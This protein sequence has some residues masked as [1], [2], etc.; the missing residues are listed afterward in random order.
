MLAGEL[1]ARELVERYLE[2]IEALDRQGPALN[3]II[4]LNPDAHGGN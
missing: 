4:E 2:R 1:T 3:A